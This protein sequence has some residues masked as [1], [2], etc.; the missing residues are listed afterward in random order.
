MKESVVDEVLLELT[1][2]TRLQHPQRYGLSHRNL[3]VRLRFLSQSRF[4]GIGRDNGPTVREL[5]S[6]SVSGNCFRGAANTP[7]EQRAYIVH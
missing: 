3:R 4:G 1:P 6:D 5:R 7:R 2:Q